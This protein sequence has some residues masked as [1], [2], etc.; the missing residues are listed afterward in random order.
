MFKHLIRDDGKNP[1]EKKPANL[2]K[3]LNRKRFRFF[4]FT[5]RR[6][7]SLWRTRMIDGELIRYRIDDER[8]KELVEKKTMRK[9][10]INPFTVMIDA[11]PSELKPKP[12]G[13]DRIIL[14]A[15]T[16]DFKPKA[17]PKKHP[18]ARGVR[19]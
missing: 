3:L 10:L 1:K 18:S 19:G 15:M 16:R 11:E 7:K 8:A 12:R 9:K 5:Q 13:I 2:K 17:R 6:A 14:K 4:G